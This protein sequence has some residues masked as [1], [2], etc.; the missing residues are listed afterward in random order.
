MTQLRLLH[1]EAM[2][3]IEKDSG[4]CVIQGRLCPCVV[5]PKSEHFLYPKS[6]Q[7]FMNPQRYR[8]MAM[9]SEHDSDSSTSPHSGTSICQ[10]YSPD[11]IEAARLHQLQLQSNMIESIKKHFRHRIPARKDHLHTK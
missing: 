1:Y 10:L 3:L 4:M 8:E 11:Q 5:Q 6:H 9:Q 2:L 7:D